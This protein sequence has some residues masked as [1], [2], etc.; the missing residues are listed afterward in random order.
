[1][2]VTFVN[3][4][5][6]SGDILVYFWGSSQ[7]S[8]TWGGEAMTRIADVDGKAAYTYNVPADA[9]N[10]IFN[11]LTAQTDNIPFDGQPHVY[12]AVDALTDK[13]RYPFT[14]DG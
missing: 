8:T 9:T 13:G 10:I 11:N 12:R 3:T 5:D 7:A 6:R 1:M 14:I 4:L 2:A